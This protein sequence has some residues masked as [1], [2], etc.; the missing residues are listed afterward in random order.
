VIKLKWKTGDWVEVEAWESKLGWYRLTGY[1]L[2]LTKEPKHAKIKITKIS[3]DIKGVNAS[4]KVGNTLILQQHRLE[5]SP[6]YDAKIEY[7]RLMRDMALIHHRK[8]EFMNYSNMINA[9]TD[10]NNSEYSEKGELH[11]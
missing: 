4:H 2:S 7:Y 1:I 5:Y 6:M 9:L 10:D 3:K 8:K 11:G